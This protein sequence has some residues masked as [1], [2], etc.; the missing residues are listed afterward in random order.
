[1]FYGIRLPPTASHSLGTQRRPQPSLGTLV[2]RCSTN[3]TGNLSPRTL[4]P[5]CGRSCHPLFMAIL[6]VSTQSWQLYD[7]PTEGNVSSTSAVTDK[8]ED[9]RCKVEPQEL[10]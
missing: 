8:A 10:S 7:G 3:I 1:M 9:H 6:W 2:L 5:N 4:R